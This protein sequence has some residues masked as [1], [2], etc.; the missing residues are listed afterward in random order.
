MSPED[1]P[2][3]EQVTPAS[4]LI[5]SGDISEYE[6]YEEVDDTS[7]SAHSSYQQRESM[8]QDALRKAKEMMQDNYELKWF[9]V[10]TSIDISSLLLMFQVIIHNNN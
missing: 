9:I 10:I 1:E 8:R 3:I 7:K 2:E 6:Y 5:N 4:H